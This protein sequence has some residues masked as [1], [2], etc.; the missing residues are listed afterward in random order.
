MKRISVAPNNLIN[1]HEPFGFLE[2]N[3][4]Q[5]EARM[6]LSDSGTIS[7]ESIIL[8]FPAITIRDSM[9]R[10][11]ALE[12]GSIIMCGIETERVLEA[13]EVVESTVRP[14]PTAPEYAHPDVSTKI[15]NYLLSTVHKHEFW[16][17]LRKLSK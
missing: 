9:E 5:S 16:N 13:I 17:G 15:T 12:A 1:F 3:K 4:L 10:P 2:Y 7:E 14:L 8:D 11:E 6:V